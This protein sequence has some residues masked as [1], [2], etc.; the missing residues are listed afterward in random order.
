MFKRIVHFG[1]KVASFNAGYAR[2]TGLNYSVLGSLD[3]DLSFDAGYFEFL[4]GRFSQ[5]PRLGI[6]GTPFAENGRTYD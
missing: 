3:A 1:G 2:L 6:A 4:V 5:D